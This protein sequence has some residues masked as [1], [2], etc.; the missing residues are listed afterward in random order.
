[1]SSPII[2]PQACMR[3]FVSLVMHKNSCVSPKHAWG[4]LYISQTCMRVLAS[5]GHAWALFYPL[6]MHEEPSS[7]PFPMWPSLCECPKVADEHGLPYYTWCSVPIGIAGCPCQVLKMPK[8]LLLWTLSWMIWC[9]LQNGK[10]A[11]AAARALCTGPLR[12]K[13][14]WAH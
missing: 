14:A 6:S 3:V 1:M 13:W 12:K 5:P 8:I 9:C 10:T 4:S 7:A 11:A 2:S